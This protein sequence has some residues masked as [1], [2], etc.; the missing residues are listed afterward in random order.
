LTAVCPGFLQIGEFCEV[1]IG[2]YQVH[3]IHNGFCRFSTTGTLP[4]PDGSLFYIFSYA[5]DEHAHVGFVPGGDVSC[6]NC[7]NGSGR[8]QRAYYGEADHWLWPVAS[9]KRHLKHANRLT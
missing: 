8:H 5:G 3:I 2:D 1:D 4:R 7:V 6:R 9:T